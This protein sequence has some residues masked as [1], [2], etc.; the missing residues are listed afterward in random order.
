MNPEITIAKERATT[1]RAAAIAFLWFI[2]VVRDRLGEHEDR[3][4]VTVFLGSGL[5]FLA[6]P[7]ASAESPAASSACMVRLPICLSLLKSTR[8]AARW[9]MR[10]CGRAC[11]KK[12]YPPL[13]GRY[14]DYTNQMEYTVYGSH[15]RL[16]SPYIHNRGVPTSSDR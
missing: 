10:S 13:P 8:L 3:F 6:M 7:F 14:M 12:M 1:P 5:L 9:S 15:C 11:T 4:F 16:A 2:G